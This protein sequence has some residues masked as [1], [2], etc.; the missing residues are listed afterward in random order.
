MKNNKSKISL[1]FTDQTFEQGVHI[2]QI[3]NS[4]ED[5]QDILFDFLVTGLENG[6]NVTCF[7]ENE[8]EISLSDFLKEKGISY[9]QAKSSDILSL[10]KTGD[11]Y[12]V[13]GKFD[14]DKMLK[15]LQDFYEE[16]LRKNR[17]GA[18]VLGEMTPKIDHI[19]GGSRLLEY[20]SKVSLLLRKFPVTTVCQYDSRQ[21]DGATIM[22]ILK[23]HPYMIVRGAVVQNP[24][25]IQP[26]VYLSQQNNHF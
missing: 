7:S 4:E 24:F 16:S 21:F 19:P 20:E 13:D 1:G 22:D 26:E 17:K 2:C 25:F 3:Y 18:R 5:R 12:F 10:Y 9:Q 23:V 11:I 14:P 8:T 6:E 15:L